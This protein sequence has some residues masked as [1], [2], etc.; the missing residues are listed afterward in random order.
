MSGFVNGHRIATGDYQNA[1]NFGTRS[2]AVTATFEGAR[3]QGNTVGFAGGFITPNGIQSSNTNRTLGLIG[4]FH[5]GSGNVP[6]N[7]FGFFAIT[8]DR[9]GYNAAGT[10][11]GEKR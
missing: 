7:Q 10:F 4:G 11:A 3:F 6:T 8:G 2:G 1:W 9:G 5:G